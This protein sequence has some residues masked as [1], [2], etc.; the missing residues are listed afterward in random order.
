MTYPILISQE[1]FQ[2]VTPQEFNDYLR[3]DSGESDNT[4]NFFINTATNYLEIAA[5]CSIIRKRYAIEF[6]NI[7]K[8][9]TPSSHRLPMGHVD[10]LVAIEADGTLRNSAAY[11]LK[12][13]Y[14]QIPNDHK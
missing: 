13:D 9:R 4:L 5:R 12:G 14:I 11:A 1:N 8:K 7:G 2:A 10:N 3:A 6:T